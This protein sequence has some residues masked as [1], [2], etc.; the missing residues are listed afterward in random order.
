MSSTSSDSGGPLICDGRIAAVVHNHTDGNWPA[1]IREN[2]ATIDA[3]WIATA[4]GHSSAVSLDDTT[5]FAAANQTFTKVP[6]TTELHDDD[7]EF[8]VGTSRFTAAHAGDYEVCASL[9]TGGADVEFE[10]DLYKN[11]VRENALAHG[12]LTAGSSGARKKCWD[13]VSSS[14]RW[15]CMTPDVFVVADADRASGQVLLGPRQA[16]V[17]AALEDE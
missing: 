10:L 11:G 6:Y 9:Y 4:Q 7:D 15:S 8:D 13:L 12:R 1:H 16:P 2:Y 14:I 17:E 5:S 3:E